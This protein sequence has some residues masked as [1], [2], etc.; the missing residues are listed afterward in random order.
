MILKKLTNNETPKRDKKMLNIFKIIFI[1]IIFIT[2]VSYF[3]IFN[4]FES[5]FEE[6]QND[7]LIKYI[8]FIEYIK[9]NLKNE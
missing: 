9:K 3:Y 4:N 8:T 6:I 5:D 1:I 2:V 7:I